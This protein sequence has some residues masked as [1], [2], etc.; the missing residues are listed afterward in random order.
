MNQALAS[1]EVSWSYMGHG[2]KGDGATQRRKFHGQLPLRADELVR[3][4][5]SRLKGTTSGMHEETLILWAFNFYDVK[6]VITDPK[7][8]SI[9]PTQM[10]CKRKVVQRD[11]TGI[12]SPQA[13][14]LLGLG[15]SHY[16]RLSATS[17]PH[18]GADCFECLKE[19]TCPS[20]LPD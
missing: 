10:Q 15:P 8:E 14:S 5:T 4:Q 1:K 19:R 17:T 12:C 7:K 13:V 6:R 18:A 9:R 16:I 3:I 11:G 2:Q 20:P